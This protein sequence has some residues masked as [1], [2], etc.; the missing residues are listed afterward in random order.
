ML[1][2]NTNAAHTLD[3]P[4]DGGRH[5]TGNKGIFR[6]VFKIPSAQRIPV[7]IQPR[8]QPDGNTNLQHLFTHGS[9]HFFQKFRIPGLSQ[10]RF[11][12]PCGHIAVDHFPLAG[13]AFQEWLHFR[14]PA[15]LAVS[16]KSVGIPGCAVGHHRCGLVYIQ[17]RRPVG[18]DNIGDAFLQQFGAGS[19]S[20]AHHIVV[21]ADGISATGNQLALIPVGQLTKQR[22]HYW[23]EFLCHRRGLITSDGLHGFQNP[24]FYTDAAANLVIQLKLICSA[25]QYKGRLLFIKT[26]NRFQREGNR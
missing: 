5:F 2:G 4:G 12:G 6:V 3:A 8:R 13:T 11:T 21:A 22:F 14:Q 10:Y 24:L 25:L 23:R 26:R 15:P 7:D 19:A 18:K 9:A 1:L 16:R 20:R 17:S